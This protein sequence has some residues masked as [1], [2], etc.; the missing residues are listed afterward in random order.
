MKRV[1]VDAAVPFVKAERHPAHDLALRVVFDGAVAAE[2]PDYGLVAIASSDPL[3][4]DFG[5]VRGED[6][7]TRSPL[8]VPLVSPCRQKPDEETQAGRAVDDVIDVVP[9]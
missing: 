3:S 7:R 1:E 6:F 5:V 8:L 4:I 2:D 9:V